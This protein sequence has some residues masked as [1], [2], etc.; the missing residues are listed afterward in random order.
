MKV[1]KLKKGCGKNFQVSINGNIL[2][3]F[4][5]ITSCIDLPT[6]P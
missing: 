4:S 3:F 6:S 5:F 2:G 1:E